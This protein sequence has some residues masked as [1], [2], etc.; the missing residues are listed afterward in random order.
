MSD[1]GF[2]ETCPYHDAV[3]CRYDAPQI[4][5]LT[6]TR[7][8]QFREAYTEWPQVN[9]KDWCRHHP[10]RVLSTLGVPSDRL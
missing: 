2:C 1:P 6:P 7:E 5:V 9:L 10:D 4:V 3:Y 8:R